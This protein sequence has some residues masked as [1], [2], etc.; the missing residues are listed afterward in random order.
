VKS[1]SCASLGRKAAV[2]ILTTSQDVR[3]RGNFVLVKDSTGILDLGFCGYISSSR[4]LPP[5]SRAGA[6]LEDLSQIEPH[7]GDIAHVAPDGMVNLVWEKRANHN[8]LFLTEACNARC[9]MCPQ[10]PKKHSPAHLETANRVLDLIKGEEVPAICITGGEPT[11]LGKDFIRILR[12]CT[13]EHPEAQID[14]LT[15]G[16][17]F[18]DF[19]FAKSVAEVCGQRARLCISLHADCDELHDA[20]V[21]TK[22]AFRKTHHGLF[23]LARLQCNIELR[24]VVSRL[25]YTRLPYLADS[26]FRTYP[27]VSHV[28]IMGLEMTG[29]AK[30]NQQDVWIDPLDYHHELSRFV[31]E[32]RRRGLNF[33]LYNHQ[34]CVIDQCAWPIARRSI[35]DWKQDYSPECVGCTKI[36][37]CC[38]VFSTS[39]DRISRG[40]API[41]Q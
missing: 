24:F 28:A 13:S 27:F 30:D 34:L 37:Q 9:L 22:G 23:N 12:R 39:G 38:G 18:S 5:F 6:L 1:F 25:N 16:Q 15:N 14:I 31:S 29:Y 4:K 41:T 33:S 21:Q 7:V 26:M 17:T 3:P 19:D 35:S 2:G 10:P 36:D 32:A 40:I 20:I 11:L 8:A